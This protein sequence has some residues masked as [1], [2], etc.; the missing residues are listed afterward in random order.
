VNGKDSLIISLDEKPERIK[1]LN[2]DG[3]SSGGQDRIH[4]PNKL[5]Y[6][7]GKLF[8]ITDNGKLFRKRE[9]ETFSQKKFRPMYFKESEK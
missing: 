6:R 3:L 8:E 4:C 9:K 2:T 1:S 7:R 5:F